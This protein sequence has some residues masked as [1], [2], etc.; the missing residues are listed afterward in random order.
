MLHPAT[1]MAESNYQNLHPPRSNSFFESLVRDP[2]YQAWLQAQIAPFREVADATKRRAELSLERECSGFRYPDD[3][4]CGPSELDHLVPPPQDS[5]E[6]RRDAALDA[7]EV[8]TRSARTMVSTQLMRVEPAVMGVNGL[9]HTLKLDQP[10]VQTALYD[11]EAEGLVQ[12]QGQGW[13][14]RSKRKAQRPVTL[15]EAGST[16]QA[17]VRVHLTQATGVDKRARVQMAYNR[18][19]QAVPVPKLSGGQFEGWTA[20]LTAPPYGVTIFKAGTKKEA[21][22]G[23]FDR[24]FDA[25]VKRNVSIVGADGAGRLM[26]VETNPGPSLTCYVQLIA[27]MVGLIGVSLITAYLTFMYTNPFSMVLGYDVAYGDGWMKVGYQEG[28]TINGLLRCDNL[29]TFPVLTP[30]ETIRFSAKIRL[31]YD[32][33][34]G[35][36]YGNLIFL[37]NCAGI[38]TAA[39]YTCTS[40]EKMWV[41]DID[42]DY[43]YCRPDP[44]YVGTCKGHTYETN[45]M[46]RATHA[47]FC[48]A[49]FVFKVF[50]VP[51]STADWRF[52]SEH[53]FARVSAPNAMPSTDVRIVDVRSRYDAE[54]LWVTST[55]PHPQP[56]SVPSDKVPPPYKKPVWVRVEP[57]FGPTYL[58]T[59]RK[60]W[61]ARRSS[62]MRESNASTTFNFERRDANQTQDEI[63]MLGAGA[64]KGDGPEHPTFKRPKDKGRYSGANVIPVQGAK[65]VFSNFYQDTFEW[66]NT[67]YRWGEEA[68]QRCKLEGLNLH[69]D[70]TSCK[71]PQDIKANVKTVITRAGCQKAEEQWITEKGP[72]VAFCIMLARFQTQKSFQT[73]MN[74]VPYGYPF[75]HTVENTFW[76][77]GSRSCKE[78]NW[79]DDSWENVYGR[80]LT[81]LKYIL[82]YAGDS[83]HGKLHFPWTLDMYNT[84]FGPHQ[85]AGPDL[86]AGTAGTGRS[87]KWR[88]TLQ[89]LQL[90][91]IEWCEH[92]FGVPCTNNRFKP[93]ELDIDDE[94]PDIDERPEEERQKQT[95][96]AARKAGAELP[97]REGRESKRKPDP[98]KDKKLDEAAHQRALAHDNMIGRLWARFQRRDDAFIRWIVHRKPNK[99]TVRILTERM[100]GGNWREATRLFLDQA[101]ALAYLNGTETLWATKLLVDV[102]CQE[103]IT[104][105][106][107]AEKWVDLTR[108]LAADAALHNKLVHAY[109]GNPV[110]P[111]DMHAIDEAPAIDGLMH[112]SDLE[113]SHGLQTAAMLMN[114]PQL[115]NSRFAEYKNVDRVRS[116]IVTEGNVVVN[117]NE[118]RLGITGLI[119]RTLRTGNAAPV[120]T[121]FALPGGMGC[122]LA[123]L[124]R[125]NAKR[126]ALAE[127]LDRATMDQRNQMLRADATNRAGFLAN[128]LVTLNAQKPRM[129]MSVEQVCMKVAAIQQVL[130]EALPQAYQ[131]DNQYSA[132]NEQTYPTVGD[133]VLGNNSPV[134]GETCVNAGVAVFPY[135]GE[136]GELHFHLTPASVPAERVRNALW[137]PTA[138]ID[139]TGSLGEA[140]ALYVTLWSKWP[141]TLWTI[142]KPT[143]DAV[144]GNLA[145]QVYV[146]S[147][148][149]TSIPGLTII[150]VILPRKTAGPNPTTQAQAAANAFAIPTTAAGVAI[151]INA[152][153]A[154]VA[155][156]PLA[157]YLRDWFDEFD[158]TSLSAF[159]ARLRM[160][161]DM[162][163][164]L[165]WARELLLAQSKQFPRL[166]SRDAA[167][168]PTQGPTAGTTRTQTMD[169]RSLPFLG[170]AWPRPTYPDDSFVIVES[171]VLMWSQ[172]MLGL[173]EVEDHLPCS[174]LTAPVWMA[175]PES[176][177][178]GLI[179]TMELAV[180]YQ[181]SHFVRGI[182]ARSLQ[183]GLLDSQHHVL[184]E[185]MNAEFASTGTR[186]N[187]RK[188]ENGE[189]AALMCEGAT[190]FR[191]KRL[192]L[193]PAPAEGHSL[194]DR[195]VKN[196][197][198]AYESPIDIVNIASLVGLIPSI[199]PDAWM[200]VMCRKLPRGAMPF[201]PP[202]GVDST[203]GFGPDHGLIPERFVAANYLGYIDP[204][205]RGPIVAFN[206]YPE[207]KDEERFNSRLAKTTLQGELV[208]STGARVA[209]QSPA[210]QYVTPRRYPL[211]NGGVPPPDN[212]ALCTLNLPVFTEPDTR[213]YVSVTQANAATLTQS[214]E[215]VT[216]IPTPAWLLGAERRNTILQ[217]IKKKASRFEGF[218][219]RAENFPGTAGTPAA[220]AETTPEPAA[221]P[222]ESNPV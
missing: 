207:V 13:A 39:P 170:V 109:N 38:G 99:N 202:G 42:S 213:I 206:E 116:A 16:D 31:G 70:F 156:L 12:K 7:D 50:M 155:A 36:Q 48:F 195:N 146:S 180:G 20:T 208:D 111:Q 125:I 190:G 57:G 133:P 8:N 35:H 221:T 14:Y 46:L 104:S 153:G 145:N 167:A 203:A 173:I 129:G 9:A 117:S 142:S 161:I 89:D 43:E 2:A 23:V 222:A 124:S 55:D 108:V 191:V 85:Q 199:V 28:I 166:Y 188:A 40:G 19:G 83:D 201:V 154:P 15:V 126:T 90:A 101:V 3:P 150:D 76:G 78:V 95:A 112:P 187:I 88:G 82:M 34:G 56:L 169:G 184:R 32:S 18:A 163:Q 79:H 11:L 177:A 44:G 174:T 106:V 210:G 122:R 209:G 47:N 138:L 216:R 93:L 60:A 110:S 52:S 175:A 71:T 149:A 158:L 69:A 198:R 141:S 66:N 91:K 205:L 127:D 6:R 218:I 212:L 189:L 41:I 137:M 136:Q 17:W 134:F 10:T 102:G 67:T 132:I 143:T 194:Y 196:T 160:F 115:N 61:R 75:V 26:C 130:S 37:S 5:L 105:M 165:D 4:A 1:Q 219:K 25:I 120:N 62:D 186:G 87:S 168:Q 103:A 217:Y 144:G 121:T 86:P 179:R 65:D 193:Y 214:E 114:S 182:D 200:Q 151:P 33:F 100:Y 81:D 192:K 128:D 152:V 94:L 68:Y 123:T 72:R 59:T 135:G 63:G 97:D 185:M 22:T 92:V 159:I 178:W 197:I 176:N 181:L 80:L 45:V 157:Q 29:R 118:M 54:P 162:E 58:N 77:V 73:A 21:E 148:S 30:N 107:T 51:P 220:S 49:G 147:A 96:R 211:T 53:T 98:H 64:E 119:P 183:A 204:A 24:L 131:P 139:S 27:T 164:D 113:D 74:E 172:A 171:D 215:R 84:S 140:I